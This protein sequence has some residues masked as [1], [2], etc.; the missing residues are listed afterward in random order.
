[1]LDKKGFD[2][3]ANDYEESVKRSDGEDSYPFA[4][5]KNIL[6]EIY[7]RILSGN[8]KDVLD[9]GFGTGV[10]A[11]GLYQKGLNVWGQDFSAEMLEIARKKMPRAVLC[12]KDFSK[13]L[14]EELKVRRYGAIVATYSLH[15]LNDDK[16]AEFLKELRALLNPNGKIYIGDVAFQT[17]AELFRCKEEYADRWD[18]DEIYFVFDELKPQFENI[19]FT[20][21]SKCSGLIEIS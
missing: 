18:E 7:R 8:C 4:G 20:R 1:M 12:Q 3:W 9:I 17:R 11:F 6:N 16:K 10:L 21:F 15:N 19:S 2:L 14:S 5:Y 13:G